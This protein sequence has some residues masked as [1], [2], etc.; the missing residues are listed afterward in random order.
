MKKQL[1]KNIRNKTNNII[2]KNFYYILKEKKWSKIIGINI[3]SDN[4]IRIF[5][6]LILF[7]NELLIKYNV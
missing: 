5:L 1:L 3:R 7:K 4:S 6:I 2:F